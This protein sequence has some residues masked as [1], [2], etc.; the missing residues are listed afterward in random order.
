M[1]TGLVED[2]TERDVETLTDESE[3]VVSGTVDVPRE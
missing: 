2:T 1:K 3:V